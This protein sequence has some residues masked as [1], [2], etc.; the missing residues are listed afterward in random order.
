[1]KILVNQYDASME[2][3]IN[4]VELLLFQD[5]SYV[6]L[7]FDE[8]TTNYQQARIWLKDDLDKIKD[9]F[10]NISGFYVRVLKTTTAICRRSAIRSI[11][12]RKNF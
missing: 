6:G 10:P 8:S 9:Y 7:R 11:W 5:S 1:M 4:Y 3:I 2:S 12:R